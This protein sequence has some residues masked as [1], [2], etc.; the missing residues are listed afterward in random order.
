MRNEIQLINHYIN[1][2]DT[3][4]LIANNIDPS[5][6]ISTSEIIEWVEDYV[7]SNKSL[8]TLET[9]KD[10]FEDFEIIGELDAVP[11]LVDELR[12]NKI[13]MEYRPILMESAEMMA[14][15]Q[16]I[17]AV[18][19]MRTNIESITRSYAGKIERYNWVKDAKARY[20]EYLKTHNNEGL[21]GIS[22]GIS[23][24]DELTG[25][26][27]EDDLILIAGRSGEGKSLMS[28]YFAYQAWWSFLK[29]NMNVPVVYIST[30]MPELEVAYRLDTMRA[31]FSNKELNQ[32]KLQDIEAYREY[33]EEL[34]KKTNSL[35]ILTEDSNKGKAFTPND[36]RGIIESER[37]GLMVVD[38]LYD[39]SDG[40]GERD[41]RK[42][43]VNV[44]NDIRDV[45][46]YTMTPIIWVAQAG[47]DSAREAKKDSKASPELHHIQESD[48]PAQKSTKVITLRLINGEIMKLSL[49]K[50]R[51]GV[52]DKDIYLRADIDKGYYGEIEEEALAF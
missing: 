50:N 42:R 5:F 21:S 4:F 40:T 47:R 12:K 29:A 52:K 51:G 13:Y 41:I 19:K 2:R 45:N 22:T 3:N 30:E 7:K 11:Y 15:G 31:H 32:G 48:T 10:K 17:E 38:Q 25:G 33:L 16:V 43:I 28:M 14:E 46:M 35:L 23:T 20:E 36:I 8:P 6:F 24:L 44:S 26:W 34:E 9:V 18:N 39:L 27:K 49:K 37:P 1:S